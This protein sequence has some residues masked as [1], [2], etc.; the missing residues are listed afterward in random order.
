MTCSHL[1]CLSIF[2]PT[3]FDLLVSHDLHLPKPPHI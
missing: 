2:T 3:L 1:P